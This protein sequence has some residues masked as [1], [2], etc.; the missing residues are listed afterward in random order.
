MTLA[1][2][3]TIYGFQVGLVGVGAP[4]LV[5]T[6]GAFV[7]TAAA[8]VTT[9]RVM[10]VRIGVG[11]VPW[12]FVGAGL[13]VGISAWYL[14]LRLVMVIHP[15]GD[16][17]P[18]EQLVEGPSLVTSLLALAVLPAVAEELVFRGV[19][20]RALAR[21]SLLLAIVLSSV[22]FSAYHLR[23]IQMLSTFPLGLALAFLAV[24]AD[25]IVP[26][27]LAHFLNN[28]IVI[29]LQRDDLPAIGTVISNHPNAALVGAALTVTGGLA[30]AA[31]GVA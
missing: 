30:L 25:S 15:P 27:M 14:D 31:K 26:S 8:V 1:A 3:L 24:R 6:S 13:C 29:V 21:R 17:K 23:P 9:A 11:R 20:A 7:V 18:L 4:V 2:V 10:R 16:T 5:A 12:R 28:A 22:V 19:L